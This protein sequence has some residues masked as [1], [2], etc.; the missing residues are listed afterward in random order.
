MVI[1]RVQDEAYCPKQTE[2]FKNYKVLLSVSAEDMQVQDFGKSPGIVLETSDV[3]IKQRPALNRSLLSARCFCLREKEAVFVFT[4]HTETSFR[5]CLLISIVVS[6][7]HQTRSFTS[8]HSTCPAVFLIFPSF[9]FVSCFTEKSIFS[10][11]TGH[12]PKL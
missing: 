9:S 12:Q 10:N 5:A 3:E 4:Q 6:P 1:S 11:P 8:G 7:G 2:V